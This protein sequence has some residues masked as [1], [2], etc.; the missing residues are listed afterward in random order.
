[1]SE[2]ARAVR[3]DTRGRPVSTQFIRSGAGSAI[4]FIHGVGMRSS[5]WDPQISFFAQ[6]HDVIALDML[7]HGGSSAPPP[8]AQLADYA[9]QVRS[10]LDACGVAKAHIVG[11]SM[12]ALVALEFALSNADRVL[13]VTAL[14]AVFQRNEEQRNSVSVRLAA[15][16]GATDSVPCDQT[17]ARWFGSPVPN[18]WKAAEEVVRNLLACLNVSGYRDTY[19]IFATSDDAHS[20]RLP[21]LSVPALFLT[22]ELDP[23]SLPAMSRVMASLAPKGR[24]DVIS[25]E[26]HMM[27]L[28]A[29]KLVNE[30]IAAFLASVEASSDQEAVADGASYRKALGGYLTGVTVVATIDSNGEARGFTA[31]SFT[32][33][34]LSPPLVSICINK[35]SASAESFRSARG[36]AVNVLSENQA[37]VSTTFATRDLD[38]FARV[39]WQKSPS[40][41]PILDGVTAWFDCKRFSAVDAGDH[42]ILIGEVQA[43]GK[44]PS[45]PLGYCRGAHVKFALPITNGGKGENARVSVGVI[46]ESDE[47]VLFVSDQAGQLTLPSTESLSAD[48]NQAGLANL[49][50][51]L[52]VKAE[53]NFLYAVVDDANVPN[54]SI[55]YRGR[56]LSASSGNERIHLVRFNDIP[57]LKIGDFT[58]S[59][60]LDRYVKERR[61]D[62]FGIYVGNAEHGIVRSLSAS[63]VGG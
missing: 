41:N 23:N 46:L 27:G 54:T 42:F 35:N 7:G 48:G 24:F 14:N 32:S 26:R 49:L 2:P 22:G 29:P 31:N 16:E 4:V 1:M 11:H 17:I 63:P 18:E 43:Y 20:K 55:F 8:E 59:S 39:A 36:F 52:G 10:V 3:A 21:H 33:V 37:D 28:T 6:S 56:L 40:G 34:S 61:E 53:I 57:S 51:K 5:V 47:R 30:R 58:I 15:L 9:E 62:L 19:R 44:T 13:S 60:M 12:G 38:R 25:G 45:N 50:A